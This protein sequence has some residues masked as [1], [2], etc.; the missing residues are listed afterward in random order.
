[1]DMKFPKNTVTSVA[2]TLALII[3][4]ETSLAHEALHPEEPL[5]K[6]FFPE[7]SR[8]LAATQVSSASNSLTYSDIT[9]AINK[10]K[11]G[12]YGRF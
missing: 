6:P 10:L 9:A 7:Q 4:V 12:Y 2:G 5:Q 3:T 1:M 8:T 11:E